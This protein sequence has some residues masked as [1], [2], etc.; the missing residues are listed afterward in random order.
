MVCWERSQNPDEGRGYNDRNVKVIKTKMSNLVVKAKRCNNMLIHN[1]LVFTFSLRAGKPNLKEV[2]E[3]DT[4]WNLKQ[5][6]AN[7]K[8]SCEQFEK[9]IDE[10]GKKISLRERKENHAVNL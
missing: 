5:L 2:L 6:N 3:V 1:Y 9:K 7:A 8:M 4:V 10:V